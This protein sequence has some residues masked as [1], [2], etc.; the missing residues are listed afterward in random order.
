M[1]LSTREG[2]SRRDSRPASRCPPA[3]VDRPRRSLRRWRAMVG[4]GPSCSNSPPWPR[5]AGVN[6]V[7]RVQPAE[8][9]PR[10]R[11]LVTE[12]PPLPHGFRTP[13]EV[14]VPDVRQ[15]AWVIAEPQ[16]ARSG[17][18]AR[19][20]PWGDRAVR[21]RTGS[22]SRG[23]RSLRHSTQ[24]ARA[25][26][27]CT[28]RRCASLSRRLDVRNGRAT[29]GLPIGT[30]RAPTGRL[31]CGRTLYGGR[32]ELHAIAVRGLGSRRTGCR[33]HSGSRRSIF[34]SV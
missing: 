32:T 20:P 33:G 27:W 4:A 25:R 5:A 22:S 21:A 24:P 19:R 16:G 9:S 14:L 28:Y 2:A 10:K 12:A 23:P 1:G 26:V 30:A 31:H 7:R 29:R 18:V 11:R 8:E 34:S 13:A 3:A 6:A 15:R 17:E